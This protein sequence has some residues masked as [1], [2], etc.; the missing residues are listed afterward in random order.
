[1]SVM[2]RVTQKV[3]HFPHHL[4]TPSG[5]QFKIIHIDSEK[6]LIETGKKPSILKIPG[7]VLEKAPNFSERKGLGKNWSCP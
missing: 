4:E 7:S 1:M 6:V 5:K 2:I 3:P